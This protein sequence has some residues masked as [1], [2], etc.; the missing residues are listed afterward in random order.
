MKFKLIYGRSGTGKST[1]IYNDIKNKKTDNPIFLIVPEQSNLMTEQNLIEYTKKNTLMNIEV[2]TLSRMNTR[3]EEELG[4]KLD[5]KLSKIGKSMLIYNLLSKYKSKLQF[6]GKTAKN[7]DT[8]GNLI[9]EFKKHNISPEDIKALK[10]ENKYQEIKLQDILFLYEAYENE[11]SNKLIDENDK[12]NIMAKKLDDSKLLDNAYIYIDDFQGFTEQEFKVVSK[13]MDKCLELTVVVTIDDLNTLSSPEKDLFYFNKLFAARLISL[14][15]S[16]NAEI[17][18]IKLDKNLRSKTPELKFLEENFNKTSKVE[19]NE[20]VKNIS[21]SL[22]KDIYSELEDVAKEIT[23]LVQKENY[24][25]KDISIITQN[26]EEYSEDAKAIFEKYN[27]PIFIDEKKELNQ[28]VII[29]FILAMLEIF[30]KNWSYEAMFTYIKSD[31]L[32][33]DE[34]NIYELENYCRKW[35]IKGKKWNKEFNYEAINK[36]QEKLEIIRKKIVGPLNNFRKEIQERKTALDISKALYNFLRENEIDK[37]LNEKLEKLESTD[38]VEEYQTSLKLLMNIL[39]ELVLIFKDTSL[40]IQK[41]KE[42]LQIGFNNSELGKIPLY[43]DIIILGDTERSRNHKIKALFVVGMNDGS[44][45]KHSREEGFLNDT[46]RKFFRENGLSVAKDS[47]ELLYDEE[48]NIYKTFS[49]PSEKLFFSYCSTDND[50]KSIRPSITLKKIKRWFPK[51]EEKSSIMETTYSFVNEKVVFEEALEKYKEFLEEKEISKEWIDY[52]SYFYKKYP[53]KFE[54][55]SSGFLYTNKAEELTDE[56]I[57]KLYGNT[58]KTSVSRLE[59]YRKCPFSFH[60][61]YGL[62]LREKEDLKIEAIDTGSFMHEVIDKFFKTLNKEGKSVKT[63]TD[64][65]I[66]SLVYK[67]I[68]EVLEESKYYI[69]KSTAKF[70]MLTKKLKQAVSKSISYII[71]SLKYSDFEILG[72][73][74]EFGVGKTYKPITVELENGKKV[75]ITGKIDRIDIGKI[76]DD[77]YVRIID[78]KSSIKKLDINQV[79]AG[80]QIQLITYLDAI[81]EEED[82]SPSGVLYLGLIDEIIKESKNLSDE[83]I[84]KNL[85]KSFKMQGLLL[86][87]VKVIKAMD[88]KLTTGSSDIIPVYIGKDGEIS[89]GRSSVASKEEFLELQKEVKETIKE[90]SKEILKGKIDIK[91]YKYQ[92]NTGCDYC[93]YKTICMFDASRKDNDFLY[94]GGS[95]GK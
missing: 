50:G 45:P 60:L 48:F 9:T 18:K 57:K 81:T 32:K 38:I 16:K 64:E 63:L 78:Y 80:L 87:D 47:T 58:L 22:S 52:I 82:Y 67:I 69:F 71:Y 93:K 70:R 19:F 68:E 24:R 42:L 88:T 8:V 49:T 46:D 79:E 13:I 90:I 33:I 31:L 36:T 30:D 2:L 56:N 3:I 20:P 12:L 39:D 27:I 75:E 37:V 7:V 83:E 21:I 95:S 62:K 44:F 41:F 10:P 86:A 74:V 76:D 17:E 53:L 73:E 61:T 84:E 77:T 66:Q 72:N 25:Y 4:G 28:N 91:P 65:D 23:N 6:L 92:K 34:Q 55:L 89:Q 14:A 43:Q 1:Y 29:Q 51:L 54:K 40:S 94:I 11:L 35:G 15:E 85:R 5:T 59:N 26:T